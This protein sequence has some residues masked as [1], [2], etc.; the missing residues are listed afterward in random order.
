MAKNIVMWF[1]KPVEHFDFRLF[2]WHSSSFLS[3][4]SQRNEESLV[5]RAQWLSSRS[6]VVVL[7]GAVETQF[8]HIQL[9]IRDFSSFK[10]GF[11]GVLS[12]AQQPDCAMNLT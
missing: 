4:S 6:R 12:A 7:L 11:W 8:E 9:S 2:S 5:S 10:D 1:P 3:S